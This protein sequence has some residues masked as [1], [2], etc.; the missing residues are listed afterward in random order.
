M[1]IIVAKPMNIEMPDTE[2]LK[3]CFN[4]NSDGAGFMWADGKTVHIRKGFMK[5]ES[6]MNALDKELPEAMR[7]DTPIVMHFRIATHGKVQPGCCHP[8]PLTDDKK[9]LA[10]ISTEARI[11]VAH[12]GIIAG[13]S[14]NNNWSDTMDF[15]A[16]VMTPLMR[17]NPSFMHNSNAIDLLEGAC[18]SKLAILDNAGDIATVGHFYE[19]DGVLYSNTSY[20][21]STYSWSSYGALWDKG[22]A[23][24]G[25]WSD[26][27]DYAVTSTYM[28]AAKNAAVN[29]DPYGEE[30][31]ELIEALPFHAC[32]GCLW[33]EECALDYPVCDSETFAESMAEDIM[34]ETMYEN[35]IDAGEAD[36][37]DMEEYEYIKAMNDQAR[38]LTKRG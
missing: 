31:D 5:F 9:E 27:D 22:Y 37:T 36:E 34:T 13:R 16:N 1:C 30:L 17:M 3:R 4:Y 2:T 38:A 32:K 11:G 25:W 29:E 24:Y 15:I 21:K 19:D 12:N 23:G 28:T 26:D 18:D 8:F 33:N 35:L 10:S 6:F 14:T 7:T 20:M